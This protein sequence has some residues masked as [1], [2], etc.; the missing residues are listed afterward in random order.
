LK[1]L[2]NPYYE[3]MKFLFI[4]FSIISMAV[5]S[6]AQTNK[7]VSHDIYPDTWVATDGLGRV[8]PTSADCALKTDKKR[9]V[10]I[11]YVTWHDEGKHNNA[12]YKMDVTK[13]LNADPNARLDFNNPQWTGGSY[14][15]GEPEN[16]YFL[17]QDSFVIRKDISMLADAGVDVLILD[18]TNGVEY[19]D[20]WNAL[21]ST[22]EKMKAEG[23]AV[24]KFCFW[25]FNGD[26]VKVVD[27]LYSLLYEKNLYKDLWF[28]WYGK[29]LLLYNAHPEV[30]AN[31]HNAVKKGYSEQ[32]KSYF[33]LRNMWWGYY[34]WNGERFLGGEDNWSFGLDMGDDNVAK[35]TPIERTSVHNGRKEEIAVTPAQHAS[36]M[37]GKSWRIGTKEP[38]LNQYDLPENTYVPWLNK[39]EKNPEGYGIYFQ[40]R[41]DEALSVDPDFIYLND[42]N[43]WTAGKY[44]TGGQYGGPG[45]FM[46]RTNPFFFVD[47]YNSEFN[48]T[49]SPMKDG[50]TDNYYMQMVENIRRYK[51]VR[52]IPRGKGFSNIKIDGSFND[53]TK[54]SPTYRDTKGDVA[55]RDHNG[56]GNNH[57]INNS[58]RN[59]IISSKVA[60]DNRNVFFY[61]ETDKNLSPFTDQMWMLLFI[62]AD[63]NSKTGW[64]GNDFVVNYKV[65]SADKTTLMK[66]DSVKKSWIEIANLS[67]KSVG[68]EM[69]IAIPRSLLNVS[70]RK[71]TF[72]FKWAD[73]PAELK[74]AISL[75]VNGDT[76]PNRRFKYR[77]IWEK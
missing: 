13:V 19:W 51:G 20:E 62:D 11:F 33:S 41:W 71:C 54:V 7:K 37:I 22:M 32:I 73:N 63:C 48:R 60:F 1:L 25:S 26:A 23:N 43:E 57:Y 67:Y 49:I 3:N 59:D 6:T 28:Y 12:P 16:G 75:C 14:H 9:T 66:Y 31:G 15:W 39:T 53:W 36:S 29:P 4:L 46:G 35:M 52:A 18:V 69:E 42:W 34:K 77:C 61:V 30:D 21:W 2:I 8:M 10:G 27:D 65:K 47:Q 55:H 70:G 44:R 72:D 5:T 17:S 56:Y 40:D 74:N 24:P 45:V 38:K 58:G 76:A 50:Y 68:H 64:E